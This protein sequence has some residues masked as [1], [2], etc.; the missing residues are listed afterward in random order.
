M[1]CPYCGA[2][3]PDD[4]R[5][6]RECGRLIAPSQP[7]SATPTV[8]AP[9]EPAQ[10]S[11]PIGPRP[12]Y[13]P[14]SVYDADPHGPFF[15]PASLTPET[16]AAWRQHRFQ[17]TFSVL[18]LILVHFL[19]FGMASQFLLARK[20]T[21]LPRIRPD[22]FS[23]AKA[24]GF[25]FIPIFGLYWV[26]VLCRRLADRL[27]LQGR[28][29]GVP[30]APSRRLATALAIG[31]V[32]SG[33]P[34]VGLLLLIPVDFVLWPVFLAQVQRF[35][36]RLALAAAPPEARSSMLALERAMRL[37]WIGW[38]VVVPCL[39]VV[40][41]GLVAVVV[42]PPGP[43]SEMIVGLLFFLA[44]AVGGGVLIYLGARGTGE[45]QRGLEASVPSILAGYLRIDKNATWTVAWIAAVLAITL[46]VAGSVG[47]T[48]PSSDMSRSEA[49]QLV[50]LGIA[51]GVGASYAV[52]RALQLKREIARLEPS[53]D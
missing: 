48:R 31:W 15:D 39:L 5:L 14:G 13:Q 11:P 35:C 28:L 44:V 24:A 2:T 10:S 23:T 26:F 47:L 27:T 19:T 30:G 51:L 42:A 4:A 45:I 36:N 50:A 16:A 8:P 40:A 34:Y 41:T 12:V 52:A 37:R 3:L 25:L 7:A 38:I 9:V 6:C 32:I 20:F 33:V 21:F 29:W 53:V 49:V 43:I 22:D 46:L 18:L 1:A 17:A